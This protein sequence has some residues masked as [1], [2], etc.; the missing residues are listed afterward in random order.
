M[1]QFNCNNKEKIINLNAIFF[2]FTYQNL[3]YRLILDMHEVTTK[4]YEFNFEDYR[5]WRNKKFNC[6]F[7]NSHM[8][9]GFE[10]KM[11]SIHLW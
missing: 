9:I 2:T 6:H 11:C 4:S 3:I 7:R 8:D 10:L 5:M 1:Y